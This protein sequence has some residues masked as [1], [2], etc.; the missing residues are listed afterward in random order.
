MDLSAY[1][2]HQPFVWTHDYLVKV[3]TTGT[4]PTITE[5]ILINAI[6]TVKRGDFVGIKYKQVA[7][8]DK[9]V[10]IGYGEKLTRP[11][12][13]A[14]MLKLLKPRVGGK[15]LDLGG[16]T[17]YFAALLGKAIGNSGQVYSLERVQW[18]WETCRINMKKYTDIQNI[19]FLYRN[20]EDGF[21]EQA[22]Y[23]GIHVSYDISS[24]AQQIEA[25]L[26]QQLKLRTGLLVYPIGHQIKVIQRL[27]IE[28]YMEEILP[29]FI[30]DEPKDGL[31]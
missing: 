17:G 14:I 23:D 29:G 11:S 26:K 10:D 20:G 13:C 6:Q 9:E 3:L 22:P 24:N 16:G 5:P 4:E 31:A 18:L 27:D 19:K 12:T 15:Y 21:P 25:K 8:L 1:G 7:Y 2:G 30:F 28:E